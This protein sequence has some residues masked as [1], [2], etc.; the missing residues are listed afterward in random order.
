MCS[1]S[2]NTVKDIVEY[3]RM[4]INL[5]YLSDMLANNHESN[6]LFKEFHWAIKQA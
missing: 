1:S 2:L 5:L 3:L 6:Q 4:Q